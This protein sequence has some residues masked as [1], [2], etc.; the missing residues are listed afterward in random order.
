MKRQI[1]NKKKL[2]LQARETNQGRPAKQGGRTYH[3]L[4]VDDLAPGYGLP[5]DLIKFL[6]R[7][8]K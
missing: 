1:R 7:I 8:K 5:E 2:R 3:V 4:I 6:K